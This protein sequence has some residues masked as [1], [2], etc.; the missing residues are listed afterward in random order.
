VDF[1]VAVDDQRIGVVEIAE[2]TRTLEHEVEVTQPHGW[3][4]ARVEQIV[5]CVLFGWGCGK[6]CCRLSAVKKAAVDSE[7]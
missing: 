2:C 3:A 6:N 1:D 5:G 7:L 4:W